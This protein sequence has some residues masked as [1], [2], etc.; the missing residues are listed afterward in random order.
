MTGGLPAEND[1]AM[2]KKKDPP[3]NLSDETISEE[4]INHRELV[5][6]W[7]ARRENLLQLVKKWMDRHKG[8]AEHVEPVFDPET[9]ARLLE[10][11]VDELAYLRQAGTGPTFWKKPDGQIRYGVADLKKHMEK[12]IFKELAA[13]EEFEHQGELDDILKN[14]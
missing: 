9:T 6:S 5:T 10:I 3:R 2:K 11:T 12:Q 14:F 13:C 4:I 1:L 7:K 8:G